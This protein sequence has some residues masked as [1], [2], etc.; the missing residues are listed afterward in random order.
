MKSKKVYGTGIIDENDFKIYKKEYKYWNHILERCYSNKLKEKYPT[1][2]KI[3]MSNKWIYFKNFKDWYNDNYYEIEGQRME[4]D[5]DI[6]IKGNKMYSPETCLFVPQEINKLFTKRQNDRGKLPIG[7]RYK[8]L[9]N[10]YECRCNKNGKSIYLGLYEDSEKAFQVYKEFKENY[11]KE[12]A[13]YYKDRIP[14]KLYNALYKYEVE[15]T[16]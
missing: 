7:V 16:D 2:E 9:N 11:I 12:I 10:K 6:L 13:D 8:E 15:I 5:K 14:N 4:I 1:Y 3:I